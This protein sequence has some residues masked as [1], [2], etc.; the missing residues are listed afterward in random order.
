M[1]RESG[2]YVARGKGKTSRKTP[3]KIETAAKKV[4]K[5]LSEPGPSSSKG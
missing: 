1:E 3:G 2:L 5:D 4:V